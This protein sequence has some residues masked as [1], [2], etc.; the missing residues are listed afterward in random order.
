MN[1][2]ALSGFLIGKNEMPKYYYTNLVHLKTA[3]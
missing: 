3:T 1:I 2:F